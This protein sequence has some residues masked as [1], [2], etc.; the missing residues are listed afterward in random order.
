MG[1]KQITIRLPEHVLSSFDFFVDGRTFR[2]R[3]HG[4]ESI[5]CDWLEQKDNSEKGKQTSFPII[6][7]K[8]GKKR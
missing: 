5:L 7:M 3:S 2:N 4:I 6:P 8:K 1:T